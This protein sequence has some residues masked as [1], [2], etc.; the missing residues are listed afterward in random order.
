MTQQLLA[1]YIGFLTS[2][3]QSRSFEYC[4]ILSFALLQW[5]KFDCELPAH[6]YVEEYLEASLSWL[7]RT[8]ARGY[9]D[10]AVD[11]GAV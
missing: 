7:L 10:S 4:K 6:C 1:H 2:L 8:S 11:L 3:D 9:P 5:S